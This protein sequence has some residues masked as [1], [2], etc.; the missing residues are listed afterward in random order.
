MVCPFS[1]RQNGFESDFFR[2]GACV[3][4]V[5]VRDSKPQHTQFPVRQHTQFQR[6]NSIMSNLSR[7]NTR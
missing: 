7:K 5:P 3:R 4:V 6:F 1:G 2:G